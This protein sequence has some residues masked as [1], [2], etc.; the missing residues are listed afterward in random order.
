MAAFSI[1]FIAFTLSL[2]SSALAFV[3]GALLALIGGAAMGIKLGG[4][5]LGNEMAGMMGALFGAS[6]AFP[7]LLIGL[8]ILSFI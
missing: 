6:A 3:V 5:D 4:K 1:T 7:A 8:L 2:G